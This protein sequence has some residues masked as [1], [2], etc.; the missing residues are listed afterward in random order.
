MIQNEF[1]EERVW[2]KRSV[3]RVTVL[4]VYTRQSEE[5][6]RR[7]TNTSVKKNRDIKNLIKKL[8]DV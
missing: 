3:Y 1:Q 6:K 2:N 4:A 5:G 7:T 8:E